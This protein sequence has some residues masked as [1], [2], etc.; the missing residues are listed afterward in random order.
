[1]SIIT[2]VKSTGGWITDNFSWPWLFYVNLLPGTFVAIAVP[3]M[4]RI[5]RGDVALLR[6]AD[7]PGMVLLA[8]FLGCLEYALEEGPRLDWMGDPTIAASAWI[9]GMSALLF[10]WRSLSYAHPVVDLRALGDR[11]FAM[12]CL[13][14]FMTGVGIFATIYLTPVFLG[15]VRGYGALQIGLAVFFTGIFQ[16]LSI[17]VYSWLANRIDLRWLMM[18]GLACFALSMWEFSSITHDWGAD[19]LLLPQGAARHG[20][21]VL[22]GADGHADAG[23]AGARAAAA[24]LGPVQPDAKPGRRAWHRPVLDHSERPHEPAFLPP[25]GAPE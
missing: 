24:R 13:F 2:R 10:V 14:S 11:N 9:S 25:C 23:R 4:V 8:L 22:G 12:G 20:P 16:I 1:V 19:Q 6:N 17:P 18:F 21:A 5:D 7:Y 15:R 3:L